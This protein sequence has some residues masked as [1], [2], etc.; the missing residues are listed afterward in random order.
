MEQT[1]SCLYKVAVTTGW[2]HAVGLVSQ[3]AVK[4]VAAG[5]AGRGWAGSHPPCPRGSGGPHSDTCWWRPWG[6]TQQEGLQLLCS[7]LVPLPKAGT[8]RT[9]LLLPVAESQLW[10]GPPH[11][12]PPEPSVHPCSNSTVVANTSACVSPSNH[13]KN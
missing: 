12:E 8:L 7:F 11:G 1:D 13:T 4:G 5:L 10:G 9:S 2:R 6:D 3:V